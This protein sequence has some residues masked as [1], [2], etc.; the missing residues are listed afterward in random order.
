MSFFKE[1]GVLLVAAGG[2]YASYL[3]QGVVQEA[4]SMKRFGLQ[5]ERFPYLKALNGIQSVACFVWAA[6]LLAATRSRKSAVTPPFWAFW[7]PGVTNSIG[8]ACGFEALKSISYPA[9]VLAKSC[10]MIPV[11]VVGT[12]VGGKRYSTAEYLCVAL[13]AGGI[14]LFASQG[15]AQVQQKLAA[16]NAPLGY[17]LCFMNLALDGYTNASQDSIHEKY[18]DASAVHTMCWMNFWCGLYYL[19]YLFGV[20]TTGPEL[21]RFCVQHRE[22]GWD[23]LLFCLCGAIG[24]LFIFFTIRR[25]GS[26]V[27]TIVTTTRKFFNIL[28]SVLWVGNPLLPQ[29]WLAVGMVF[30]GLLTSTYIKT[31]NRRVKQPLKNE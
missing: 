21:I 11:M 3:T 19:A 1:T 25:Y 8:P 16:P 7:K 29:Q 22:A 13:I 30:S 24:Q 28:L 17:F 9:Q 20:T 5:Q 2:I 31:R 15:S 10:K 23:L 4:L 6:L 18:K 27:T 14:S 12:V 26:L